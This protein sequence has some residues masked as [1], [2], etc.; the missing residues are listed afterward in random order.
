MEDVDSLSVIFQ[1]GNKFYLWERIPDV[2]SESKSQD[3]HQIA[4]V[5]SE[6]G[7]RGLRRNGIPFLFDP[8]EL[9]DES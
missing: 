6:Q 3:L 1:S 7:L 2:L 9:D 4:M 8:D 5:L